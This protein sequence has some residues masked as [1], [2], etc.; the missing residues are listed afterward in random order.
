MSI[1][2]RICELLHCFFAVGWCTASGGGISIMSQDRS[3]V[4]V[5][6]SGV[7][8]ERVNPEDVFAL[9]AS[10]APHR[11]YPLPVN[12][13]LKMSECTPLFAATY[14]F[15]LPTP[16]AVLHSH[17]LEILVCTR[18]FQR[19][20]RSSEGLEMVKGLPGYSNV[21]EVVL[22]IIENTPVESELVERLRGAILAYPMVPAVL[23]RNHGAY[24]WG[25]TWEKAKTT[26]EALHF[27]FAATE[28]LHVA[29]ISRIPESSFWTKEAAADYPPRAWIMA[30]NSESKSGEEARHA[31][32]DTASGMRL[33]ST[34]ELTAVGVE[35]FLFS[36]TETC[37]R[38]LAWREVREYD[39]SDTVTVSRDNMGDSYD[40][41][42]TK[43]GVEH[44]HDAAEVRAIVDGSGYFDIR[45][46][47]GRWIRIQV[48]AGHVV[49]LP[50][51]SYHRFV[52]DRSDYI[53]A[54]RLFKGAPIWTPIDKDETHPVR[55]AY[56]ARCL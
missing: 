3:V 39:Y 31:H 56:V 28:R 11:S 19:E 12:Q 9:D 55:K 27:L 4:F 44:F 53:K 43:F 26:A 20:F 37:P 48:M 5:A 30:G 16:G 41:M 13:K 46:A 45:S 23:V 52:P 1:P 42:V 49:E 36:C 35:T 32:R 7:Q 10:F 18:L 14:R 40:E 47:S 34:A 38:L 29:G 33:L 54:I 22:P 15:A 25:V 21:D 24:I 50:A 6:P 51:G 2:E 17:A 8:K